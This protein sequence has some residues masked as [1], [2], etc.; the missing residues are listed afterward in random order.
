[1]IV[2]EP[3]DTK[4][5]RI[6]FAIK[7]ILSLFLGFSAAS[8]ILTVT[9]KLTSHKLPISLCLPYVDPS[10]HVVLIAVL[11]WFVF[12]SALLVSTS[13][14]AMHVILVYKFLESKKKVP[15]ATKPDHS[16]AALITQLVLITSTN[17]ICW[18]S[19]NIIY[20][21]IMFLQRYPPALTTWS[22]AVVMPI[23]SLVNPCIFIA[24]AVRK[25]L[26]EKH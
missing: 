4:F 14:A 12:W 6:G 25:H 24:F 18:T 2:L 22:T 21:V 26:K 5:K 23:S 15:S 8:I 16:K 17:I 7:T 19:V 13:M 10:G 11:V 9:F 1:M 3:I 20:L